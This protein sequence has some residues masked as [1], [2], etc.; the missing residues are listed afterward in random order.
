MIKKIA[1]LAAAGAVAA[2][3]VWAGGH[4]SPEAQAV[5]AR[6]AHMQLYA[7]NL[8][9]LGGMARGNA[10]YDAEA[11]SAA[12]ANMAALTSMAQAAYWPMG[13]DNESME[14]TKALP[15]LWTDFAGAA[16]IGG[17]L[18]AAS[19]ALAETAGD[20]L[21]ALQAGMGPVGGACGACHRTYR[22]S[23]N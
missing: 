18:A 12:A 11:A 1:L 2:T 13:T 14:G 6:K 15:N 16:K 17:D 8:G 7:F 5:N 3:A 23:D 21:E 9:I 20:G 22:Q 19:A 10:E 4:S